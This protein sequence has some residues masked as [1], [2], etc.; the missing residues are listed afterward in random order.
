MRK[1]LTLIYNPTSGR[2][3]FQN[4]LGEIINKL[5]RHGYEVTVVPTQ[6][7]KHAVEVAKEACEANVDLLVA[8]GGDGT[9]NEVITG[10]SEHENRPVI[11][12]I[13]SG[14]TND[15]GTASGIGLD[16]I[17]ATNSIINGEI[18]DIDIGKINDKYFI[19]IC[20]YGAFTKISYD[21][22]SSLK[23]IF[24]HF[25]YVMSGFREIPSL[26]TSR[27]V[28]LVLDDEEIEEDFSIFLIANTSNFAG[29]KGAV[30][31]AKINDGYLDIIAISTKKV[32]G[33][34]K[35]ASSVINKNS[36]F[37]NNKQV[38][39]KKVKRI[40]VYSKED[41]PINWNLDGELGLEGN[42]TV[43]CLPKHIK[44]ILPKDSVII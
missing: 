3:T 16:V 29:L 6:Y 33:L 12:Y 42:A 14:T 22:P 34:P 21:T 31:N 44:M 13:P 17:A 28:R 25:A 18:Y 41:T 10:V 32:S 40:E 36:E 24:G 26:F 43:E 38:L 4:S 9:L 37:T 23:T 15:F 35:L 19:N 39:H 8:C 2:E 5:Y 30:P 20:G 1:R 11:G 27:N 7:A